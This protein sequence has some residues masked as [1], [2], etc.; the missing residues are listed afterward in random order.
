MLIVHNCKYFLG[1]AFHKSFGG[2]TF[3]KIGYFITNLGGSLP[4]SCCVKRT[5]VPMGAAFPATQYLILSYI[6]LL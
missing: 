6:F 3:P 2:G 1:A 4:P 5:P